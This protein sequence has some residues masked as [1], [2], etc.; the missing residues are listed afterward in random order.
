[1]LFFYSGFHA[2]ITGVFLNWNWWTRNH[3]YFLTMLCWP[4]VY[5]IVMEWVISGTI[6]TNPI[7]NSRLQKAKTLTWE[8]RDVRNPWRDVAF[9]PIENKR[10]R[11]ITTISTPQATYEKINEPIISLILSS[12]SEN[13]TTPPPLLLRTWI[14]CPCQAVCW[15]RIPNQTTLTASSIFPSAP[16]S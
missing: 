6:G 12:T 5:H 11:K 8:N 9:A 2:R 1:M 13:R 10:Q 4:L 16:S 15:N 3:V 14:A 7:C